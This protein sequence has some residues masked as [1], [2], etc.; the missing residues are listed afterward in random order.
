MTSRA[1]A[2]VE[3]VLRQGEVSVEA[4]AARLGVSLATVRRDLATL[5][6]ATAP[7][8]DTSSEGT[9]ATVVETNKPDGIVFEAGAGEHAG[10]NQPAR[11]IGQNLSADSLMARIEQMPRPED[12]PPLEARVREA[13]ALVAERRDA[14][15]RNALLAEK[16]AVGQ[17]DRGA[18]Q[19]PAGA[20][21]RHH[22]ARMSR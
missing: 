16:S 4:L 12:L 13:E 17:G 5:E 21:P 18:G 14:Y 11:I 19:G 6:R 3:E 2:I 10:E 8:C 20:R 9:G 15:E 7:S 22:D 1:T